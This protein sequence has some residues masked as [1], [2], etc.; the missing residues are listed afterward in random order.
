MLVTAEY[1]CSSSCPTWD[2]IV[3]THRNMGNVKNLS[4]LKHTQYVPGHVANR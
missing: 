3:L 4:S 1:L 2:Q